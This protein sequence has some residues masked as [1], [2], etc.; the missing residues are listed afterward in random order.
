MHTQRYGDISPRM[1]YAQPTQIPSAD[2]GA[3]HRQHR[4]SP[5]LHLQ[6]QFQC[7]RLHQPA[8]HDGLLPDVRHQ[9]G[10]CA[11]HIRRQPQQRRAHRGHHGHRLPDRPFPHRQPA[12]PV[13]FPHHPLRR[14]AALFGQHR[15]LLLGPQPGPALRAAPVHGPGRGHHGHGHRHHRGLCGAPPA[16]R[17]G[18][19]PV[20]HEH[21]LCPGPGPLSGHPHLPLFQLYRPGTDLPGHRPGLHRHLF[22]PAPP[23]GDASPPPPLPGAQQL[24]RPARG[25]LF[26]GGAHHLPELRLHPG[27][28]DLLRGGTRPD[29]RGQPLLPAL[30]PGR[31]GDTAPDRPPVRPAR[32]EHHLLSRPAADGPFPDHDGP[33]QQRLD[34][35][36]RR[37]GPGRGFRQFPVRRAGGLALAGVQ[38]PLCPGHHDLFHLLRSGHRPGALPVRLH[39]PQRGL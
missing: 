38:V 37:A 19:Q 22:R 8:G 34:A 2:A 33:R 24:H 23:A 25:A 11:G 39:G 12:L 5:A 21:G 17:A 28:H 36:G 13:R 29:R 14:P 6:P 7:G 3:Q 27:F 1:S 20:Q 30:R 32:R 26:A 10:L 15:G 18:H 35:A 16:S 9:H 31:P 4:R